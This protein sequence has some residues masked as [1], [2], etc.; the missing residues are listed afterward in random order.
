MR[1]RKEAR[2]AAPQEQLHLDEREQ[3]DKRRIL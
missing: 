2:R 1:E 3:A